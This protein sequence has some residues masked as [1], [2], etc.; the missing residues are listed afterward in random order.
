M[1]RNSP[2]PKSRHGQ[3]MMLIIVGLGI[4][5][6]V[7]L[8]AL[9]LGGGSSRSAATTSTSAVARATPCRELSTDG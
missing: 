2:Q 5:G 3:I 6:V 9:L 8:A 1:S 7:G 4:L